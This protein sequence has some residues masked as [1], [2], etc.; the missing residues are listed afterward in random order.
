MPDIFGS[1]TSTLLAAQTAMSMAH[2]Q[3]LRASL[4]LGEV[5]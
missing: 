5:L 4:N 3:R 1:N 2:P